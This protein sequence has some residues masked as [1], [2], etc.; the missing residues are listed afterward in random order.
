[1]AEAKAS[2]NV[3]LQSLQSHD[4]QYNTKART[5]ARCRLDAG[6]TRDDLLRDLLVKYAD[7]KVTLAEHKAKRE[8]RRVK[9]MEVCKQRRRHLKQK[10]GYNFPMDK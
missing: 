1:M 7:E 10:H 5:E 8:A 9:G 3:L 2:W 4:L 6:E